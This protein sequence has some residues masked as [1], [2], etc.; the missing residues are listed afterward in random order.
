V[1]LVY[2]SNG[3]FMSANK[4][5]RSPAGVVRL[6]ARSCNSIQ[7]DYGLGELGLGVG[8]Q[9]LQRIFAMEIAGFPCRDFDARLAD[10]VADPTRR[11][12]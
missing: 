9:F 8:T 6:A 11:I 2:V 1:P 7:M 5:H 4:A 12:Q 10:N 3:E